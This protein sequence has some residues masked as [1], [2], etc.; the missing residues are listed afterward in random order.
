[1]SIIFS[2]QSYSKENT[3]RIASTTS[4]YDSG[5]LKYLN[6]IFQENNIINIQV[7]SQGT[8]QAIRTAEDGNVEVLLVHHKES[9]LKFIEEGY[10]IVRYDLMYNDFVIVGPK[11]DNKKCYNIETKLKEIINM[12]YTFISR[13][14]DSGTHKKELELWNLIDLDPNKF[15]FKNYLSVGQGMGNTLLITNEKSAY[16]LSDRSTWISFNNKDNLK[17]ICE[18]KPPLFNQYGLILINPRINN[19]LNIKDAK[20]YVNW[21]IS[22]QGKYW[23]NNYKKNGQQLFFYNYK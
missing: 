17:I 15:N 20:K 3:I 2:L 23:I 13:G 8:G 9:E 1:M 19:K 16:A 6:D 10:G 11:K 4:T 14:D 5:L 18:N 7:L 22:A 12:K 21:L